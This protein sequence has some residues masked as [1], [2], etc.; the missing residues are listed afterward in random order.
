MVETEKI[1]EKLFND[2]LSNQNIATESEYVLLAKSALEKEKELR[3][4]LG[5]EQT[6]IFEELF[7]LTSQIHFLEVKD[8]FSSGC[9]FGVKAGKEFI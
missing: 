7:E 5:E 4:K 2:Y 1:I 6:A 8:A 3:S 9:K